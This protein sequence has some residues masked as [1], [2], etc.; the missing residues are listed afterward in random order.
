VSYFGWLFEPANW[1]GSGG[2][3]ARL[4]EHLGYVALAMI[5]ALVVDGLLP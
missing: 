4:V 1:T 5:I 2:V 3:P